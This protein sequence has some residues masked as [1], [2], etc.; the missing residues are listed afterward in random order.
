MAKFT[1][2]GKVLEVG[3]TGKGEVVINHP[4]MQVDENGVG[5]IIFSPAQANHLAAILIAKAAE[6]Q[7]ERKT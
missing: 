6:A 7:R 1:P 2:D 3:T 4:Q 5:F